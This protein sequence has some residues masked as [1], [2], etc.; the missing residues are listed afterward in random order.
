MVPPDA[1]LFGHV[2]V[3]AVW[4]SKIGDSVRAAKPAEL[5]KG[6]KEIQSKSGITPDMIKSVTFF[7]PQLKQPGDFQ[8]AVVHLLFSKP[9]DRTKIIESMKAEKTNFTEEKGVV[10]ITEKGGPGTVDRKIVIDLSDASRVSVYAG[11]EDK[12]RSAAVGQGPISP[13]IQAAEGA[14]ASFGLNFAALPDEI[15]GEDVPAEVRPFQPLFKSDALIAVGKLEGNELKVDLRFRSSDRARVVEAEKSLAAGVNLFQTL[16]GVAADQ[17]GKSKIESEKA[18]LP[19]VR[20]ASEVVKAAKISSDSSEARVSGVVRTDIPVGSF[21]QFAL[22]GATTGAAARAKDQNNLKQIA[23]AMHNYHDTYN[24]FPP[25]A[26]CD[27]RGKPMLSWR[28]L[29]LPYIEQDNL[30]RQFKLDEPWDST[31]NKAILEKNPIPQVYLLPGGPV[32]EKL[33][34]YQVFVKNGALFD[35]LQRSRI[36]TITDGTS[37]TILIVTAA[38]GVPWTKPDDLEF[39]P[40]VDPRTLLDMEKNNGCSVA[41]ADGSVR[42][43]SKTISADVLRALIT[44]AGGEVVDLNNN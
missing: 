26:V 24:G 33:T 1:A 17:L 36:Q 34:H 35:P 37:N 27:R 13:A 21:L 8:S 10:T 20:Q 19:L 12:F 14:T 41:L 18:L 38:K 11:V 3:A 5:E 43:L 7:F 25:A 2:D 32:E 40:K 31:H 22:G 39:D 15:R 9:Y 6:L 30:Y 16:L 29:I 23:L 28:V 4:T 42:F 44:K